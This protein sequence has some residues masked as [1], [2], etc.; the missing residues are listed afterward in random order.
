MHTRPHPVLLVQLPGADARLLGLSVS[1][2]NARVATRHDATVATSEDLAS[3]GR[4]LAVL[5]PPL[6]AINGS[7][8]PLPSI[9]QPHW[10]ESSDAGTR[11]PAVLAGPADAVIAYARDL[12]SA[13]SLP[14]RRIAS[15]ALFDVSTAAAAREAGWRL[16]RATTKPTDGW[17]SRTFNRPISQ[18]ISY[19]ALQIGCTPNQATWFALL[20]GMASAGVG[21]QPGWAPFAIAGVLFQLASVLDGVD[22]E[23]ART[24]LAESARGAQFDATVDRL[25]AIVC[26]AGVTIGWVREG[27]GIAAVTWTA[28]IGLGLALSL[29][30][31]FRFVAVHARGAPLL[32]IDRGINQAARESGAVLLRIAARG[33]ALLRRDLFAVIFMVVGFTGV[34][35]L[36]PALVAAGIVIANV[37]FS[38]Y[39][40]EIGAAIRADVRR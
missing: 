24:T 25:T 4:D 26:F 3:R 28:A 19:A 10:L 34:R 23:I 1:T 27:A 8:F 36:V 17:I 29:L 39:G 18:A 6:T 9:D 35:S 20:V 21:M 5:V 22:G 30:R 37:T 7:L 33:F 16:L 38:L 14:R 31:A 12:E 13:A 11:S 2:R 32:V 15:D 40:R